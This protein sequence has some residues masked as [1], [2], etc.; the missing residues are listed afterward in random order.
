MTDPVTPAEAAAAAAIDS[1]NAEHA[2]QSASGTTESN[3]DLLGD[4]PTEAQIEAA[5]AHAHALEEQ[6]A[7]I[8]A[9][10]AAKNGTAIPHATPHI[11]PAAVVH[12]ATDAPVAHAAAKPLRT[13][14]PTLGEWIDAGYTADTYPPVGYAVA[15]VSSKLKAAPPIA[16][17]GSYSAQLQAKLAAGWVPTKYKRKT[18]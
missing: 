1:V 10:K 14:G 4:N 13:D 17:S 5:K 16:A 18:K 15:T 7:K 8:Q 3:S 2:A 6:L 11:V 12:A 9:A